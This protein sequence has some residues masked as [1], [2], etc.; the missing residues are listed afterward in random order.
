MMGRSNSNRYKTR[1]P[2][3]LAAITLKDDIELWDPINCPDCHTI[4]QV[5]R[6]HPV[7]LDYMDSEWDEEE[8]EDDLEDADWA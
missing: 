7:K 6:L 1:C 4:L 3:C 2:E 5:I 8:W